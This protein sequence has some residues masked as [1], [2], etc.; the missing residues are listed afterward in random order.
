MVSKHKYNQA[1]SLKLSNNGP[2]E[3]TSCRDVRELR[4]RRVY[5]MM[6]VFQCMEVIM[7]NGGGDDEGDDE[8][9]LTS[10]DCFGTMMN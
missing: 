2:I 8:L 3:S 5:Y 6:H 7:E 4:R 1:N 9:A 10:F